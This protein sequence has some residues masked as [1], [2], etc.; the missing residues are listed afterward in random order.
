MCHVAIKHRL[1]QTHEVWSWD[2]TYCHSTV[3][4]Q[5][6]YLYMIEDIYSR[7]IVG[8]EVHENE[9]VIKAGEL[10]ERTYWREKIG[11]EPLVLHSDNGA[12]M[13]AVTMKVKM[14]DLGNTSSYNRPRVRKYEKI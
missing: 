7:K 2:I 10:L 13:K 9:C 6:Y 14:E 4:G 1:Q 8:Y 12:P 5:Y 3:S 11:Q